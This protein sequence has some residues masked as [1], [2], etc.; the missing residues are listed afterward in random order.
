MARGGA[1]NVKPTAIRLLTGNPGK[2]PINDADP[3][4]LPVVNLTPPSWLDRYGKQA[5]KDHA[6]ELDRMGLLTM[7]LYREAQERDLKHMTFAELVG[8]LRVTTRR[9]AA[10]MQ[11]APQT[12]QI[13]GRE[14]RST[15]GAYL[16]RP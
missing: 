8:S 10:R 12:P 13:E 6:P 11:E 16:Q 1:H 9:V 4:P 5:W 7:A 15:L 3:Q 14:Q 2:G